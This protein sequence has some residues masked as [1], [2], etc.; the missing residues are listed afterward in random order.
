MKEPMNDLHQLV[1]ELAPT[2]IFGITLTLA[3]YV[4]SLR[5]QRA[6]RGSALANPVLLSI[7]IIGSVLHL[8]GISYETYFNGAA[9]IHF[10]LGPA[11]VALA[12]PL[13]NNFLHL[14]RR[15][16]GIVLAIVTGS[17]VSIVSGIGIVEMLGGSRVIAFSMAPKAA[18]TPIAMDVSRT[19]GGIPSLTAVLAIS[20]GILVAIFIRPILKCMKIEDWRAFGL[21]AGTA[22]SGIGAARAIPLHETAGAFAGLA[23]GLNGL[24]TA[25]LVPIAIHLWSKFT[26]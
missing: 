3:A 16:F 26:P 11:T 9:L 2:P 5:I 22:G 20:G 14:K 10:L 4:I 21:A 18:T 1:T 17:I 19:F 7:L 13:A 23:I 24:I 8:S 25:L 15:L 6:A 12:V